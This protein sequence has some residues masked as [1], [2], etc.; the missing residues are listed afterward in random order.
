LV[1]LAI[2]DPSE[3]VLNHLGAVHSLDALPADDLYRLLLDLPERD[4]NGLDAPR[5]YRS[6]VERQ[7]Y[8]IDTPLRE[9]FH[10]HGMMWGRKDGV[11]GYYPVSML[12][13]AHRFSV[14]RQVRE[15]IPLVAID[16]RRGAQ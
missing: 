6:L 13:Y 3:R 1:A 12:R 16:P 11:D 7:P 10:Q 4:P 8:D 9:R 14:P 15:R 2:A 5:I